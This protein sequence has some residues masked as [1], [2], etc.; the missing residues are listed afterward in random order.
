MS[1]SEHFP[2]DA[3]IAVFARFIERRR[4][5]EE[6]RRLLTIAVLLTD[7]ERLWRI[8]E[9]KQPQPVI[10]ERFVEE[11]ILSA[12]PSDVARLLWS[13]FGL[14]FSKELFA[15]TF[16]RLASEGMPDLTSLHHLTGAAVDFL[17]FH[18]GAVRI[19]R[20]MANRLLASKDCD[21]R[22]IGL[23]ALCRHCAANSRD[24]LTHIK[25]ALNGECWYER[26]G[27]IVELLIVLDETPE[28]LST[29]AG[30]E[31]DEVRSVLA[32]IARA[33]EREAS[34][35]KP[36]L[37]HCRVLLSAMIEKRDGS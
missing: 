30:G 4:T 22:I 3:G 8:V 20:E 5:D 10:D 35:L 34:H 28:R 26:S 36:G 15:R 18:P 32:R 33:A 13:K 16:Y 6:T 24:L 9:E 14:S 2:M 21:H 27:G 23:K 19:R 37:E 12:D 11:V 31:L 1:N 17:R 25:G 29:V 7:D